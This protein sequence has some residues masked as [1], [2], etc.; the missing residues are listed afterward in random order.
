MRQEISDEE[1]L[2]LSDIRSDMSKDCSGKIVWMLDICQKAS[3]L[4][5]K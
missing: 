2:L 3:D 1:K 5:K 4:A